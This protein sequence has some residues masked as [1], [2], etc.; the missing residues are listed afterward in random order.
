MTNLLEWLQATGIATFVRESPSIFA[1]TLVLSLHA[2]GLAIV[3]GVNTAIAL[4]L[5]GIAASIP[6]APLIKLFP[7]M[8]V[9]FTVNAISGSL[10][11]MAS[12]TTMGTSVMFLSKMIFVVLGFISM[13]LLRANVFSEEAVLEKGSLPPKAKLFAMFSIACWGAAIVSGR[14]TAYPSFVSSLLG[15]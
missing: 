2:M 15:L 13:E 5:L 6:V 12:A 3:V 1:Y 10:L 9:G 7:V 11:F 8:Y 4:R 14:L